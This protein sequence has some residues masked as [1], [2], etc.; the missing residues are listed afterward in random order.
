MAVQQDPH[1]RPVLHS[2][3]MVAAAA[4]V[5]WVVAIETRLLVLQ[6]AQ[7]DDLVARAERFVTRARRPGR[8]ERPNGK[9]AT[10][11]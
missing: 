7:H 2:R 10:Q 8:S 6:V 11:T 3:L 5:L 9:P 1:W 4:L